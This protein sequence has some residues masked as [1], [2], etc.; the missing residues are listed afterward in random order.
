[1]RITNQK[2]LVELLAEVSVELVEEYLGKRTPSHYT[3]VRFATE[4]F[5]RTYNLKGS[6]F[7]ETPD[8]VSNMWKTFFT[9]IKYTL[10]TFP[11][12]KKGGMILIKNHECWSFCPHHLL[13]VKYLVK[14]G[15]VPE[16]LV[17]GLSKL[18]R[19]ADIMMQ[20]MPL[21]EDL[22]EMIASRI[23]ESIEPKGVGV[24]VT[25]EHMCMKMRGVESSHVNAVSTFMWGVFLDDVKARDEFLSL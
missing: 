12:K 10:T 8:R 1:M 6:N 7:E 15:Y 13:P 5:L 22:A 11:L 14:V 23:I 2:Q 16:K 25:G 21:Q 20:K 9:P 24:V 17:L 3:G 19:I 18:A 4:A